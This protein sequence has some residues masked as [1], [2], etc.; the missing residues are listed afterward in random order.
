MS[1]KTP[2]WIIDD[3]YGIDR[4]AYQWILKKRIETK[5]G[6]DAWRNFT[7]HTSLASLLKRLQFDIELSMP[8][9]ENLK[10]HLIAARE[11]TLEAIKRIEGYRDTTKERNAA[12]LAQGG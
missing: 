7:F 4:D 9:M 2:D 3:E 11:R 5:T 10:D 6:E 1:A 12:T 8:A